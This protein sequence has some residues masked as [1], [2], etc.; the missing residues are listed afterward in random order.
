MQK[1]LLLLFLFFPILTFAQTDEIQKDAFFK[2]EVIQIVEQQKTIFPDGTET[3][4]QNLLLRGLE[5]DFEDKKI[6]FNGIGEIDVLNKNIYKSGDRVLMV[7]SHD[8]EGS[9]AY[10]ITDYVRTKS[11]WGLAIVFVL[12]LFS[13][14]GI[15]GLRSLLALALTFLVI[16]KY[17][18]PQI[19]SGASPLLITLIGSLIILFV[20]IYTTEG[21]RARSHLAA[22]SIFISLIITILFSLVFVSLTKLT[23]AASEDILFL[24][25]IGGQVINFQGLLLAGVI[26]GALGVL[27]D[28]VISQIGTV[29]QIAEANESLGRIEIFKHAYKVGVSHIASMTNTLFLAYAGVSLPLLILFVSGESAFLSFNQIINNEIIATEVVRTLVG[30]IGL[31][32]SVPIATFIAVWWYGKK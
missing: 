11:L 10:Y 18:V 23:G 14:G 1:I 24:F 22:I 31:I 20:I 32:L 13:V 25:N 9:V 17:I 8:A 28:V 5:G 21:F 12:V 26:I 27:D 6:N 4:Q 16:I 2:A 3:E 7:A 19:L 29:E 15:K 30:S